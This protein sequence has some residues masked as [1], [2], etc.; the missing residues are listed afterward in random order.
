MINDY[1]NIIGDSP[2]KMFNIIHFE[3]KITVNI[4]TKT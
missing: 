4:A 3:N 2:C 1:N